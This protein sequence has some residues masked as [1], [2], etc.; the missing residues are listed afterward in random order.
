L[1]VFISLNPKEDE[2]RNITIV[3]E[4][5]ENVLVHILYEDTLGLHG[6]EELNEIEVG[7]M[8]SFSEA[9]FN[10]VS[11]DNKLRA[12][13]IDLTDKE[14]NVLQTFV[15][16][17]EAG[18]GLGLSTHRIANVLNSKQ[19]F[20]K[21]GRLKESVKHYFKYSSSDTVLTNKGTLM[22]AIQ[23]VGSN[24]YLKPAVKTIKPG[25]KKKLTKR[26]IFLSNTLIGE[27]Y[28]ANQLKS[29]CQ[30]LGIWEQYYLYRVWEGHFKETSHGYLRIK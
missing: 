2:K 12:K 19:P 28:R 29:I 18:R 24:K 13:A 17:R 10:V 22:K 4:G 6:K 7:L 3:R 20:A 11:D 23:N 25:K 9:G 14:G 5:I 1:P 21:R 26:E 27:C 16:L 15:S 30:R 8:H